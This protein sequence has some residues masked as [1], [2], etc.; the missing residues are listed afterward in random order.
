MYQADYRG[1]ISGYWSLEL[2]LIAQEILDISYF[3]FCVQ[4]GDYIDASDNIVE[5][6]YALNYNNIFVAH[7]SGTKEVDG[8][9][10]QQVTTIN[11]LS[12]NLDLANNKIARLEEEI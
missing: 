10:E 4:G 7:I 5:D 8:I 6:K 9:V 1:D 11:D 2:G 12:Q 3:R